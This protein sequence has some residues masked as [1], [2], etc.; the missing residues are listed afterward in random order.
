MAGKR[1]VVIQLQLKAS[2]NSV[3]AEVDMTE[4]AGDQ[5][6]LPKLNLLIHSIWYGKGLLS[7]LFYLTRGLCWG[8]SL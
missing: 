7:S 1:L 3:F 6:E 8:F 4:T 2:D 5:E